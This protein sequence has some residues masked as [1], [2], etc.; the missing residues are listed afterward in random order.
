MVSFAHPLRRVGFPRGV[1]STVVIGVDLDNTIVCYD[2]VFGPAAIERGLIPAG[3]ADTKTAVR[4]HLRRAGREDAW[5]ELQGYVYGPGMA[6]A[7]SFPGVV[8]FFGR[9]VAENVPVAIISHRTR[10]PFLGPPHDL[11]QSARDWLITHGFADVR[12]LFELTPADKAAR[13]AA[14]GCTHFIDDLP[15]FLGRPD[16]PS[17]VEPILFGEANPWPAIESRLFPGRR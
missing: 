9:C 1:G 15:E 4:D 6:A 16:F 7:E 11:H 2:R 8:E 12:V 14:V 3:A 5:T 10:T 13:I 17:G